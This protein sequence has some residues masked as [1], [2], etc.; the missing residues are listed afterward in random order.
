MARKKRVVFKDYDPSQQFLLPPSLEELISSTHAVRSVN[1]VIEAINLDPLLKTYRGGGASSYH[2][3]MMLKV[4]IYAYLNNTYSSRRIEAACKENIHFMWLSGMKQPDHNTINRFR[5]NRLKHV[6]KE[7][8]TEVVMLLMESGHIDLKAVYT[9]GTKIEANA[10][11][12]TFV[13]GKSIQTNKAKMKSQLQELW[14]YTQTVAQDELR[15]DDPGEFS[16]LDSEKVERTIEAI[17]K[18][19]EGKKVDPKKKQKLKYAQKQW[20]KKLKEYAQK[21]KQFNGRSSYSKTDP[22]ATFMRMKDDHM[23]NGQL[24]A[25]YNLQ[26]S[27]QN[28]FITNYSLHQSTTDTNTLKSH[29]DEFKTQYNKMPEALCADAGYGS[30]ENY[31]YLREQNIE[32]YVKFNYFHREQQKN[33]LKKHPFKSENLFYNPDEDVVI[34]PMGQP[35][36]YIGE[37]KR[38]TKTGFI[39]KV[40]KYQAQSCVGCPLR[41]RCHKST[42]ERIVEINQQLREFKAEAREKLCSPEGKKHRSKR[43]AEVEAVFGQIKYNKNFKRFMLR[44]LE[45]VAT[46]IGLIATAMN[47]SK[48]TKATY[49]SA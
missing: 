7:V 30:E 40:R 32:A 1:R 28:Q 24:K 33:Y 11:K 42:D 27:T 16:E 6:M 49:R 10:N 2:P 47:I 17:N 9:D 5:S 44:G 45:K 14:D 22:D 21:E 4:L 23:G 46:E 36:K 25:A 13:W 26:A 18:A 43:P 37:R 48:M 12:Y 19:L 29:C 31:L 20:P 39:Q 38:A 34:C 35:M 3:K 8:F 15:G 41:P